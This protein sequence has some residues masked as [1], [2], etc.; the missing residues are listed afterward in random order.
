MMMVSISQLFEVRMF[1]HLR[2]SWPLILIISDHLEDE[3]LALLRHMW[4]QLGDA[5]KLFRL[6][7]EFHVRCMSVRLALFGKRILTSRNDQGVLEE[8]FRG[9][10]GSCVFGLTRYCRE[11]GETEITSQRKHSLHPIHPFYNRNSRQ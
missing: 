5:L 11:T 7:V 9:C 3:I 6:K 8:V 2:G 4:Y 1:K 10:Y